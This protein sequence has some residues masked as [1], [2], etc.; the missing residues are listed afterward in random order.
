[1]K[2]I[3][4][5]AA[6]ILVSGAMLFAADPEGSTVQPII[7]SA[8][9]TYSAM[10]E[11][12]QPLTARALAMGGA[13]VAVT[14]RSDTF[15]INPAS[16]ASRRFQLSIPSAQVTLYHVYDLLETGV[17]EDLINGGDPMDSVGDILESIDAGKGKI[18][19]VDAGLSFTAGGFGLGINARA[20]VLTYGNNVG[21]LNAKVIG[22]VNAAA[23]IGYGYRFNLPADFSI[24]LGVMVRFN[25]LAYT[26]KVGAEKV[27]EV[28]GNEDP[29]I[30][31]IF[32]GIPV[33]AGFSIPIDVGLNLNMPYGFSLGV[34]ARNLNGKYHM[35]GFDNYE[36]FL[37]DPFGGK[38]IKD[39]KFTFDS[40]WSLD[41]GIGWSFNRWYFSPTIAVDVRDIVGLAQTKNVDFRD[42]MYH[43][44]IGAEIRLLSFLDVRGGLSQGYWTL[45][46]GID[47]WA[48]KMDIA[49]FSQEF[50]DRVGDNGLDGLTIRF[51][52]GF[53]R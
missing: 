11:P 40:D 31:S 44:N 20:S 4:A 36:K 48:I 28:M 50:G 33:M 46:V 26:E 25:Y 41:A 6:L 19:D 14:G 35:T 23:S 49:Y 1:M 22:K 5:V 17:V 34:V 3:F 15:Y 39:N 18:A 13:G 9:G 43:L 47:L 45:G 52:I 2:K 51:N 8:D 24:D 29:D 38:V 30:M 16:L 7:P 10:V 37:Q 27:Q 12:F 21:A 32:A 53:D 42:F